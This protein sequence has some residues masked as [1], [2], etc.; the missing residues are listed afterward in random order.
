[1]KKLIIGIISFA[2]STIAFAQDSV[3]KIP[4]HPNVSLDIKTD[5]SLNDISSAADFLPILAIGLIVVL[6][7]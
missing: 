6:I 2:S 4:A 5:H 3:P 7:T 1:M